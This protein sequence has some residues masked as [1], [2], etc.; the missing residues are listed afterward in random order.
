MENLDQFEIQTEQGNFNVATIKQNILKLLAKV[1]RKGMENVINYLHASDYFKAPASTQHHL[2]CIG[3][4]ALH[5]LT[6]YHTFTT[7]NEQFMLGFDED[8]IILSSLLH[9]ACK[10]NLYVP[11]LTTKKQIQSTSKP[12]KTKDEFPVGHGEKSVMILKGLGL[13]LTDE[14]AVLIRWHM[15]NFEYG[16]KT[17]ESALKK[18]FPKHQFLFIADYISTLRG[19]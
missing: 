16:Y 2:C 4:L 10:I 13:D 14:E 17:Y 6:V 7:M 12:F 15:G 11:N 18:K 5:S 8:T 3:G 9:D 1:H 19:F